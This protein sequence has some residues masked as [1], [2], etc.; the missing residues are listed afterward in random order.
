MVDDLLA[1]QALFNEMLALEQDLRLEDH[2]YPLE[3]DHYLEYDLPTISEGITSEQIASFKSMLMG[4]TWAEVREA[5][6]END[7]KYREA[8]RKGLITEYWDGSKGRG[9]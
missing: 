5:D 4:K 3:V 7:R 8:H 9:R 2:P 1:H 6:L